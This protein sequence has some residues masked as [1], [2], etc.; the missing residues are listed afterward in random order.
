M[1]SG[2]RPA[3]L[4]RRGS[5]QQGQASVELVLALPVVVLALLLVVQ[6]ALVVRAQILVVNAARE[7]ARA[8]A[9]HTSADGAARNTPG[10]RSDR[11]TVSSSGGSP[12]QTVLVT[13]RYR[14]PTDVALI[15]PLLGDPELHATVA[16]RIEDVDDFDRQPD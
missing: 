4:A 6:L 15:G 10:L 11:V 7:G 1:T 3:V 12:G 2:D 5:R 16:M 9:V 8:A 14:V 13:V